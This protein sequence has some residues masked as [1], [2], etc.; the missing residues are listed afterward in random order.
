MAFHASALAEESKPFVT[1]N[2]TR[3]GGREGQ[4]ELRFL[5]HDVKT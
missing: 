3:H 4:L 5:V 2:P 1:Q